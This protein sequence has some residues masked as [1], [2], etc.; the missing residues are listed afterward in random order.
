MIT[1]NNI[2]IAQPMSNGGVKEELLQIM[3]QRMLIDGSLVRRFFGIKKQCTLTWDSLNPADYQQL[4]DLFTNGNEI[5]YNNPNSSYGTFTFTGFPIHS[6]DV[7][8]P[9]A[10]LLRKLTV[11][12][13]EV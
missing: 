7:Y 5:T 4:I 3:H 11:K 13:Q 8:L 6:E 1:I 12:I 10:T 9:G 2:A